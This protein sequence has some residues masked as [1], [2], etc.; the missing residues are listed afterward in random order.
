[1]RTLYVVTHP[2]AT[3][4]VEG[5]VGGWHD[6]RL[7]SAG[8][9]AAGAIARALRSRIP[10]GAEVEL[11][12]SD[13]RR[14]MRTAE[15]AARLFGVEP[16]VDRRLREKSYG[17]AEGRPQAWLDERFVR[18]PAVGERMEHDE[19]VPGAETKAA[20]AR[21]VYA[22]MDEILRSP[23]RHQ[24]VVTHGGS[25]TFVVASWIRMPVES[26]DYVSFRAP[27]GSIT[28]LHEDDFFHNRQVAALGDTSHLVPAPGYVSRPV[29]AD[30]S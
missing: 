16:V 28:T 4:H 11:F 5:V 30:R 27:S 13:L 10:A 18:P 20:W 2:E 17:E 25:L 12:S 29:S 23:V 8:V 1:M 26:A 24:I 7:T 21:R 6:S 14:T 3:H 9:R 15:E 19:G 22:A